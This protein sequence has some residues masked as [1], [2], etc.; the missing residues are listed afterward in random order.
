MR[1]RA[2]DGVYVRMGAA[3]ALA[4]GQ[5]TFYVEL[6]E[7]ANLLHGATR[8]SLL[9]LDELGR[10]T[11]TVDGTAVAYATLAHIAARL[12]SACLF[13]THYPVRARLL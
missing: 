3:D 10:G 13:V 2:F 12:R 11:S 5:S 7:T 6:N 8:R 9:L 1:L 4:A